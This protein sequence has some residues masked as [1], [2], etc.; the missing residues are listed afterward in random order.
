MNRFV[1]V[2]A[3]VLT[4]AII[5]CDREI[6]SKDPLRSV[7]ENCPRIVNLISSFAD[8]M[9]SVTWE[10]TD[11]TQVRRF[12]IYIASTT[13]TSYTLWDSTTSYSYTFTQLAANRAYLVTVAPVMSTGLECERP[14]PVGIIVSPL[15]LLINNDD[16][17]TNSRNVTIQL[18]TPASITDIRLYETGDSLTAQWKSISG[19]QTSFRLSDGDG[20]KT[21]YAELLFADGG[22]SANHISDQINLDRNAAIESVSF[23]PTDTVFHPGNTIT[24]T[25]DAGESDGTASVN[26]GGISR[27]DLFETTPAGVYT[28]QWTVP[29]GFSLTSGLVAGSFTDAAGNQAISQT[30]PEVLRIAADLNPVSLTA[31][32]LSSYEVSLSWTQATSEQFLSYRVY[33]DT[34]ASVSSSSTLVAAISN[35]NSTSFLDDDLN[36]SQAYHYR[37]YVYDSFG[38]A[39]ASQVVTVTTQANIP[40][41]PIELL[42]IPDEDTDRVRLVWDQSPAVDF[43]SYR[44][45]RSSSS[46]VTTDS[47]LVELITS[48]GTT[49]GTYDAPNGT[50]YWRVFVF[51]KQGA[52]TGSNTISVT[53]P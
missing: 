8:Q 33:R 41:E 27:L 9:A 30:A 49:S 24:F 42:G 22:R 16:P 53:I 35:R 48:N 29:N 5:A 3:L 34:A 47:K 31:T 32:V 13:D 26:F 28:R 4:I 2:L 25:L 20:L 51:D 18:N 14:D 43:A 19:T 38:Q 44:V 17:F 7:P 21:V 1:I 23:T 10:I 37:V 52:A 12:R 15:T 46:S 6:E 39:A 50:T 36:E 40:P 45:Y 11:S